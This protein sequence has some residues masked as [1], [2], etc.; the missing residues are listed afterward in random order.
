MAK[1]RVAPS[2]ITS[3]PRLELSAAVTSARMSVMLKAELEMKID[4]EFFWTDCQVVLAYI[5]NE[6]RRFHVLVANCIQLIRECTDPNQWHYVD[7]AQNPADHA[8]RGLH[9]ADISSASWLSGPKFLWEQEMLPPPK[10]STELLVGDPEVKSIQ[11]FAT[12]VSE[13]NDILSR[14]SRFSTWTTLVKVVARIKRLG[15]KLKHH[16]D[17]V[18]VDECRRATEVLIKLIQKQAFPQELRRLQSSC[19]EENL[20]SSSPLFC[21]HS[22]LDGGLLRIG[23]RLKESALSQEV[24]HPIILPKDRHITKLI[25]SHYHAQTKAKSYPDGTPSQWILGSWWE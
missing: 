4:E 9:A 5:N 12:Q 2:K 20:V 14:L 24:K 7:T 17:I 18:T 16:G 15:S 10:P 11:V 21:L 3:I 19:Q 25:L 8:S 6:A 22:I 23:A 13:E 1:A